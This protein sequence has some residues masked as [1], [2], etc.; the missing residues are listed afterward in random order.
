MYAG[1]NVIQVVRVNGIQYIA[2]VYGAKG[3]ETLY[4]SMNEVM[5]WGE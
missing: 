5:S 3:E 1:L 4:R 2:A